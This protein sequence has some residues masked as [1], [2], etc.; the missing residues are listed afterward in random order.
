MNKYTLVLISVALLTGCGASESAIQTALAETAAA[1]PSSTY[2]SE[3]TDEPT[4]TPEP[5]LT[6]TPDTRVINVDPQKLLMGKEDIP[7]DGQYYLPASDWISPHR[8]SEIVSDW[9]VKEGREYLDRTGRIDGW[10]VIYERG[11]S[12]VLA[13]EQIYDNVVLYKNAEGARIVITEFGFCTEVDTEYSMIETDILV[14]D[15]TNVCTFQEMQSGGEPR[16]L[17]RLEFIYKNVYHGIAIWGWDYE[18]DLE[19]LEATARNL[20]ARLEDQPLSTS[21]TFA[22]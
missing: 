7:I 19:F 4:S 1:A 20:L 9:G 17:L 21:V 16:V 5:T 2:T 14:G 8:N 22:P 6:P 10:F 11:T 12:R 15:F 3:P 13:P 18:V